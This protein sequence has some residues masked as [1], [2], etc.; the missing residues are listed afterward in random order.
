MRWLVL[1]AAMLPLASFAEESVS[2]LP[3]PSAEL[4]VPRLR[5]AAQPSLHPAIVVRDAAGDAVIVSGGAASA[6]K[7][8]D[9]CHDVAWIKTHDRH[10]NLA[11]NGLARGQG[12]LPGGNCFLCH[13]HAADNSARLTTIADGH[14][15][16]SETAT[17]AGTKLISRDDD[18][19]QWQKAAFSTDGSVPAGMLGIGRPGNRACGFCHGR[20][21]DDS[22]P[23]DLDHREG[24]RMTELRGVVFSG[25]RISDSAMNL[26]DKDRL[27]RPWDVHAERM[28]SCAGCHFS[29]NHPAY[30]FADRGPQHLQFDARRVA[31]TEYLR[32]PDHRLAGPHDGN[33]RRCES[34]HDAA[35]VH[36]FLPRAEKHFA[37][38]SCEACHVPTANA[39]ARQEEDWTV[40]LPSH[41]PRVVYRGIREDGFVPGFRP[42]L[43]PRPQADG[44]KKLVPNN[45]VTTYRWVA[46][47]TP[48][49]Q[50]VLDRAFVVERGYRPELVRALDRNENGT[51]EENELVLDTESKV[52]VAQA[53][54]S[55]A[56]AAAPEIVGEVRTYELHHGVSPGRFAI[57]D[58]S[59]CHGQASRI[60]QP[61]VAAG[62]APFGVVP[63]LVDATTPADLSRDS[64]GLLVVVP[65]AA[66]LHVFG[67]T[68]SGVLDIL[69]ILLFAGA[70]AGA[71]GH[72]LLRVRGARR[73]NKEQ[74]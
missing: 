43:L 36:G 42:V 23:L 38:L 34:C 28:V 21:H 20:V 25:Q 67:H 16:W 40:P 33:L 49:A 5:S 3:P 1:S 31:I 73:R 30:A 56:G 37:A 48:V 57:R 68:R 8:C 51:L 41:G 9:G 32:R 29:P 14:A 45:V 17:L 19:W 24:D 58:C 64:S 27:T 12:L 61:M 59:T 7:T 13:V 55:A 6:S 54:L 18:G 50:S 72:A 15:E 10:G 35:K 66:G 11:A 53:L 39:P 2:S 74:P 22:Q 65:K 71:S 62:S 60:D 44:S 69:G 26:A 46:K 4:L 52:E 47:D 70:I 63:R